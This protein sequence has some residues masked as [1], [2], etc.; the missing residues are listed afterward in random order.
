MKKRTIVSFVFAIIVFVAIAFQLL[1]E[2]IA[3]TEG[4]MVVVTIYSIDSLDHGPYLVELINL[5]TKQTTV[6]KNIG[7]KLTAYP[8]IHGG[9]DDPPR[10]ADDI[11]IVRVCSDRLTW[12]G[13]TSKIRI[14]GGI[15]IDLT[16]G[17]NCPPYP[18]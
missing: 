14:N 17:P 7:G 2:A 12:G 15:S 6:L 1:K 3:E 16:T 4:N 18:F 9:S 13:S 10:T 11:Y 8:A 5:N